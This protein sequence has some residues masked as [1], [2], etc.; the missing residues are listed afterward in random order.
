MESVQNEKIRE[1]TRCSQ[2]PKKLGSYTVRRTDTNG[3]KDRQQG[4]HIGFISLKN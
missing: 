3:H 4:E 2:K 1:T